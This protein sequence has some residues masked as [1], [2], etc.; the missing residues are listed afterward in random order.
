MTK[1]Q[2][3]DHKV[4]DLKLKL[5]DNGVIKIIN[6]SAMFAVVHLTG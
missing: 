1:V 5:R 2:Y 4:S 6:M 3:S